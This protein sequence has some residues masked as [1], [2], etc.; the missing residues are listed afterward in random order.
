MISRIFNRR[1]RRSRKHA[2]LARAVAAVPSP[3]PT[4]LE[5]LEDRRLMS[6]TWAA[7][8][9]NITGTVGNDQI[10]VREIAG[11]LGAPWVQVEDNGVLHN[12]LKVFVTDIAADLRDGADL[13]AMDLALDVPLTAFGGDG[14]DV[15]TCGAGDDDVN[16]GFDAD[17]IFGNAGDDSLVGSAGLDLITGGAGNDTILGESDRDF[18]Y[19][20][21][22]QD[23]ISGGNDS[24]DYIEGG[25]DDDHLEGD[26]GNDTI[27]GQQ[28][29]D[30]LLGEDGE[31]QLDGGTENDSL[32]GGNQGDVMFGGDG[33]DYLNGNANGDVLDGGE[34]N[35]DLVG[36]T[37]D[38]DLRGGADDDVLTD[39]P[40][41]DTLDGGD[42]NDIL[43]AGNQNDTLFGG[44]G[45]DEVTGG[46]DDDELHGDRGNDTLFG[47]SGIDT[48]DGDDGNDSLLGGSGGDTLRGGEDDDILRGEGDADSLQGQNGHDTL[49]GGTGLDTLEGGNG[50]DGLFGGVGDVDEITGGDGND[51]LLGMYTKVGPFKNWEDD[52][53]DKTADDA[54]V[55]FENDNQNYNKGSGDNVTT[56]GPGVWTDQDIEAIDVGLAALHQ[57]TQNK[58]LLE[59]NHGGT[60]EF[61]RHGAIVSFTGVASTAVG[62]NNGAKIHIPESGVDGTGGWTPGENALHEIGH[63][64]D[65]EYDKD[66]WWALSGWDDANDQP[67]PNHVQ[68]VDGYWFDSTLAVFVSDYAATNPDEDF[69]ETFA[70]YFMN[71]AGLSFVGDA[72]GVDITD[73]TMASKVAF[74]D[75]FVIDQM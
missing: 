56:Y 60:L 3:I 9:V 43:D 75:Q 42:G 55:G 41:E 59:Q 32:H 61:V 10:Y 16:G 17:W 50:R 69:S 52:F 46:L 45:D 6:V 58:S 30:V 28:G 68:S 36:G 44:A 67:T 14:F 53:T 8:V 34:D 13:L 18:L 33:E 19:G 70:A 40:G 26:E 57:A 47:G 35:D 23:S 63:H 12:Y 21:D 66:G 72:G 38:D 24:D 25:N 11:P 54:R 2:S 4:T 73:P 48:L 22:G 37:G 62:W 7:G 65:R 51:R 29:A 64:W 74:F 5:S 15:I 71:L 1:G 49:F 20:N 27:L 39:D 31:D